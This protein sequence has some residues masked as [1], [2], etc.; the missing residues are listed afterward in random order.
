MR[1]LIYTAVHK[2][3]LAGELRAE[4]YWLYVKKDGTQAFAR[5]E[6]N[7]TEGY[8]GYFVEDDTR[9]NG[10]ADVAEKKIKRMKYV[11]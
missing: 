9:L 2:A 7:K 10:I 4:N 6:E 8:I 5:E 11:R 1:D 3:R